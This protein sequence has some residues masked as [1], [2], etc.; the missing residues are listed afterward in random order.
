MYGQPVG[1]TLGSH[2]PMAKVPPGN[3]HTLRGKAGVL[4]RGDGSNIS[5]TFCSYKG[6]KP[7]G[8]KWGAGGRVVSLKT[9]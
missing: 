1:Q 7:R 5:V 4:V 2:S 3:T 8:Y 6:L 9:M